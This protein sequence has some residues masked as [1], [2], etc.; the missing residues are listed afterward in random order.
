MQDKYEVNKLMGEL[1]T[2]LEDLVYR[3][4]TL[5]DNVAYLSAHVNET[6]KEE[7]NG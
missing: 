6:K 5:E 4:Y 2:K 3:V 1:S 7:E